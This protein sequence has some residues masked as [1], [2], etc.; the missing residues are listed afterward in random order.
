MNK[1]V[2]VEKH[3]QGGYSY[4]LADDNEVSWVDDLVNVSLCWWAMDL[5]AERA[6][7]FT[8]SLVMLKLVFWPD[9]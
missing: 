5:C 3:S 8:M 6:Q 9:R 7:D 4:D 2:K 1:L